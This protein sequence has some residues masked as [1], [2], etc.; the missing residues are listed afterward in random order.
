MWARKG[1]TPYNNQLKV[2]SPEGENKCMHGV[3][4][5]VCAGCRVVINRVEGGGGGDFLQ[6]L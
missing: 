6:L 2:S 1:V 5:H 4:V 3:H